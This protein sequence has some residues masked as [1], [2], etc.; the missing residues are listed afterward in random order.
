MVRVELPPG[1]L[2]LVQEALPALV[3]ELLRPLALVLLPAVLLPA[4]LL[5]VALVAATD[6][7]LPLMVGAAPYQKPYFWRQSLIECLVF[8]FPRMY[9]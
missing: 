3:L 5:Q 2:E 1:P 6:V 4:V 7:E 8:P 9:R